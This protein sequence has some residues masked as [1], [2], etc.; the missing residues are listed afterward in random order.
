MTV[1]YNWLH[2]PAYGALAAW[3]LLALGG[4]SRGDSLARPLLLRAWLLSALVGLSDELHQACVPWRDGDPFD[5][6]TDTLAAGGALWYLAGVVAGRA[7]GTLL[8]RLLATAV[9]TF[10]TATLAARHSF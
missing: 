3:M 2:C 5:L 4:S 1:L 10:G 7:E 9:A 6:A 8:L